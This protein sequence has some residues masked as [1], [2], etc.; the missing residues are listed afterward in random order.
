MGIYSLKLET[1][2]FE[3]TIPFRIPNHTPVETKPDPF[4]NQLASQV[5]QL[6]VAVG[7]ILQ[8]VTGQPFTRA[9]P[10]DLSS[11]EAQF[12]KFSSRL[13]EI[14]ARLPTKVQKTG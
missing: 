11:T 12:S 7:Q 10:T 3:N 1:D 13:D 2:I 5:A 6:T 8:V 14:E 9:A 4:L